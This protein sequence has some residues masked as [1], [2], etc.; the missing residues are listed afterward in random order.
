MS[1][2]NNDKEL[3]FLKDGPWD[4]LYVL[5]QHWLSD[6]QFYRDDL[7][8]LHHLIDKYFM[9]ITKPENLVLVKEL[10]LD[11]SELNY[12]T[13]DLLKKIQKHMIQLGRLVENSNL[14]DAGV[15]KTEHEHL[16]EEISDFVKAFRKNRKEVFTLIEY[17]IDS[18][19][20]A[21]IMK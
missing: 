21:G 3:D 10:R 12:K 15:V 14:G 17:I 4:E 2:K 20:L 5:T 7:R 16:E 1:L 6:L 18:E 19:E 9:W 11:L 13:D 8:F